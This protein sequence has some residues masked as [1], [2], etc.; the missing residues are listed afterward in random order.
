MGGA[1]EIVVLVAAGAALGSRL[2]TM[3]E[4]AG[5]VVAAQCATAAEA[6]ESAARERPDVCIVDRHLHGGALGAAIAITAPQQSPRVVVVGGHGSDVE[7]RA[8]SL[9]GATDYLPGVPDGPLLV[10]AVVAAERRTT[11]SYTTASSYAAR[12]RRR[13]S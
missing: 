12:K 7:R 2:R 10:A 8:A 5:M 1:Q 9:A 6:I 11:P 3:I 4:L 13:T